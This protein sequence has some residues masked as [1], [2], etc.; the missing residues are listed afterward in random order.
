MAGPSAQENRQM[1]TRLE[2]PSGVSHE[3]FPWACNPMMPSSLL[4]CFGS[5]QAELAY[6][7]TYS[8]SSYGYDGFCL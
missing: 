6:R 8:F 7:K 4:V 1:V 5:P 2:I 3:V